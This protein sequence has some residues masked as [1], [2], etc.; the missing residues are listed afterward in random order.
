MIR[1]SYRWKFPAT[2]ALIGLAVLMLAYQSTL[3][4]MIATWS[5]SE[6]FTHGFLIFPITAC[7]IWTRRARILGLQ[8]RPDLWAVAGML[9]TGA[10]WMI[11]NLAEIQVIQQFTL[12]VQVILTLWAILGLN[13]V[14]EMAFPL[15]F[16]FFAVPFGEFL[17]PGLV[18]F[19][20]N[21]TVSVIQ[22]TGIPIYR[23]G[24]TFSLPT[25]NWSV[26]EACSGIRYLIASLMLGSLFA[27]LN[28]KNFWKRLSFIVISIAFPVLANGLRAVMIVM[29]GHFSGMKFAVGVDHLIYGWFFFGIVMMFMFWIGSFFRDSGVRGPDRVMPVENVSVAAKRRSYVLVAALAL[30]SAAVWPVQ[31]SRIASG[32]G[33]LGSVP[34]LGLPESRGAWHWLRTQA[35]GG[36]APNYQ[37][38]STEIA[39]TY[40]GSA[41]HP[42][43]LF[44][45]YYRDQKQGRELINSNNVVIGTDDPFWSP[46]DFRR[47]RLK[48]SNR[49][50][51]VNQWRLR[52]PRS[53]LLAW[54]WYWVG[55]VFVAS[56]FLAKL[57]E[58]KAKLSGRNTDSAALIVS[59]EHQDA[60]LSAADALRRFVE[61]MLP[62]LEASLRSAARE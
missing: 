34:N 62:A 61:D 49:I 51:Q 5:N 19:T 38:A 25:G 42:V 22:F 12:I 24:N 59:V 15:A 58:V 60:T 6:T 33:S 40:S 56:D 44:V 46:L 53:Q 30:G 37:G 32:N 26:V 8:A 11:A 2:T 54:E 14:R 13:V 55:D 4:S 35:R 16:M 27:Y 45:Y 20:A 48:L 39:A 47:I 31:V 21:F 52:S 41:G 1:D 28:Y 3:R 9:V 23:D 57:L 50:L 43:R 17:I 7:L 10:F 29:I 18:H 36:W